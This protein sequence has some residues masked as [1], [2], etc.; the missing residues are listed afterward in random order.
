ML[1][2]LEGCLKMYKDLDCKRVVA[3][4]DDNVTK[5]MQ[6]TRL[7]RYVG[8]DIEMATFSIYIREC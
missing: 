7:G 4:A 1:V 5:K 8:L 2:M 3:E 6:L